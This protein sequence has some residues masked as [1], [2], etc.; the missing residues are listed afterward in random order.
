MAVVAYPQATTLISEIRLGFSVSAKKLHALLVEAVAAAQDPSHVTNGHWADVTERVGA[1]PSKTHVTALGTALLAKATYPD[2]DALSIK[3][4]WGDNTYSQRGVGNKVLVPASRSSEYRFHPGRLG[5]EP[6]NNQPYFRY[7]HMSEIERARADGREALDIVIEELTRLNDNPGQAF[8]ALVAWLRVR[9]RIWQEMPEVDLAGVDVALDAVA[10]AADAFFE[11]GADDLPAR[12]Q[13]FV[14]GCFDISGWSNVEMF[15]LYDPS[16]KRPG[17]VHGFSRRE[18]IVAAEARAKAVT[19]EDALTFVEAC[20]RH[21]PPIR[22]AAVV[23]LGCDQHR[24]LDRQELARRGREVGVVATVAEG[25]D[26]LLDRVLG[27]ATVDIGEGI[28][29]LPEAVARR[30]EQIG[31]ST[32]SQELWQ[33]LWAREPGVPLTVEDDDE[34]VIDLEP[35]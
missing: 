35:Q 9:H 26:E 10:T 16:R 32:A 14:A 33:A 28:A 13:A 2:A 5:R 20:G 21:E 6:L 12:A 19:Q 11:A 23:V 1:S 15:G 4:D 18:L 17:D 31:A 34:D 24:P 30:L 22:R 7:D 25:H 27:W 8:D 3:R 29:V